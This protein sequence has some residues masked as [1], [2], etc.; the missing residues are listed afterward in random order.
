MFRKGKMRG[1]NEIKSE[2]SGINRV[3]CTF[4][5]QK[6]TLTHGVRSHLCS[7]TINVLLLESESEASCVCYIDLCLC[8]AGY[9]Q[10]Y[11]ACTV[12]LHPH[13]HTDNW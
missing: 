10:S 8:C 3:D 13:T 6:G 1:Y 7:R 4:I 11:A 9:L 2:S 12:Q 5:R